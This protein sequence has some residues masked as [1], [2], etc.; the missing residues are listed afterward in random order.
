MPQSP[1]EYIRQY[2]S[3][4][5]YFFGTHFSISKTLG[6]YFFPDRMWNYGRKLFRRTLSVGD[7]VGKKFTNK[8]SIS[9]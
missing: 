3:N 5:N 1:T 4:G 7:L 9:R 8:M 6:I 2:M